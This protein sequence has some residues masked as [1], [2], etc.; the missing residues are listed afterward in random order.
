[1]TT[2]DDIRSFVIGTVAELLERDAAD[3]SD[4]TRLVGTDAEMESRAL[5]ELMLACEDFLDE[6]FGTSFDWYSDSALSGVRSRL[7]TVGTLV[8]LVTERAGAA[9]GSDAAA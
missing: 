6:K 7:R 1:M 9:D 5:V 4:D 3:V 2:Q 8:E